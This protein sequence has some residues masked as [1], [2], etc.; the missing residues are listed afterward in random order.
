MF[1]GTQVGFTEVLRKSEYT[2]PIV[3]LSPAWAVARDLSSG[4]N[5][6]LSRQKQT[7][8]GSLEVLVERDP[9]T[10]FFLAFKACSV[11]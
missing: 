5:Y 11:F 4:G 10:L 1:E 7:L 6:C 3:D 9:Y 8:D 2:C